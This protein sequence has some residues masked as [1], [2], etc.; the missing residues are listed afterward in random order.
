MG[1]AMGDN[2]APSGVQ[3]RV[4]LFSIRA[5]REQRKRKGPG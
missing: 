2:R 1:V 4:A 3:A 5:G